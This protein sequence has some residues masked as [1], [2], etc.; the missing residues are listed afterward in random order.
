MAT[1]TSELEVPRVVR[2][3]LREVRRAVRW[4]VWL[5][6]AA[7][8]VIALAAAFWLGLALDWFFEPP[9][10]VR[11]VADVLVAAGAAWIVYRWLL[12]RAFARLPDSGLAVLL[13][14]RFRTLNDHLLTAVDLAIGEDHATAYHPRLVART[15]EAAVAAV[16]DLPIRELFDR[17]TLAWRL[18]AAAVLAASIGIFAFTAREAFSFW[19]ERIALSSEL[20]PRRVRLEVV[21]F[22]ADATGLRTHK[23]A[24]D[25]DFV[26]VVH[27]A[28]D[29]FTVPDEVEVRFRLPDGRRGRDT[30]TRVGE[31]VP[32][33]DAFQE[34][35]Y[36]FKHVAADMM[37]DVVGGDDR[38]RNLRLE[39]VDRPE[40]VEMQLECVY[41]DYLVRTPRRLPVTG[42]MRIPEGT[43][44]TLHAR[45]TKPLAEVRIGTAHADDDIRLTPPDSPWERVE[46]EYGTLTADDV[47][48]IRLTDEDHVTGREPYRISLS[49]VPDELPQLAVRLAGIGTA[50]TPEAVL[51]LA[52]KVTDDY[53]LERVWFAYRV[54]DGP[55]RERP[56]ANQPGGQQTLD[57]LDAFDTRGSD[58]GTGQRAVRL[59]PGQTLYLALRA[60]DTYNL[61]ETQRVGTSQVFVLDVV[62]PA[63]LLALMERRELELRQ[64][65]EAIQAKM[66]DTRNLLGRVEFGPTDAS[67]VDAAEATPEEAA[68][69]AL[70]RRRL[71]VGG[72]LQNVT[73]SAAEVLGVADGFQDI[74]DQL[75]NNRVDNVDLLNRLQEQIAEPLRE[76]GEIRMPLLESKLQLV[77]E[78][79]AAPADAEPALDDAIQLAD[80]ILVEMQHVLERMLEL[81]SY[82]EV[83]A[84]LRGIIQDQQSLNEQTKQRQAER[85]RDLLDD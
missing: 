81:E 38:V 52:G 15:H 25:D 76:L 19:L 51:P 60:T 22:P 35:R 11:L 18:V 7:M 29:G 50:I 10:A 39:I 12:R 13:E 4:Y 72:S 69:R 41:P 80:A 49:V 24:L 62:T 2:R 43:R 42:G 28:T 85:L 6:G 33:R 84:L 37:L 65:F 14:R 46:W 68:E 17:R 53:G 82:N 3:K 26:L 74:H 61:S 1:V 79:I 73:Q 30:M 31:A 23:L 57:A 67:D 55:E 21:G 47:L 71:R 5:D 56:L 48:T 45:S 9:P 66:T 78:R 8:L 77:E 36:E 70:A 44:L 64:R 83:V 34:F 54:D 75:V 63:Q 32:G 58:D 40:L 20:W 27:A 16:A 59:E